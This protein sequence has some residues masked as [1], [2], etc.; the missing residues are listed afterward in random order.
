MSA[1]NVV[2]LGSTGSIGINAL[3]VIKR[4]EGKFKVVGLSAYHNINLLEKQIKQFR[5]K[6]I[7]LNG[8]NIAL[9]KKRIHR[10][11][12]KIFDATDGLEKL[13]SLREADIIVLGI[14][15]S[16]ALKPFLA[17]ARHGKIIAPANKEALVMA[18]PMIMREA[19]KHK[20]TIIPVEYK[21][22]QK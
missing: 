9:L 21:L 17:A 10:R 15:G 3:K 7:A 11:K 1:K 2:I 8:E 16:V 12:I 22:L 4:F 5:P 18:G 20:A 13:A 6:Y 19:K 14:Q